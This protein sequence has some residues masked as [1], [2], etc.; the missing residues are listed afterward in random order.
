[1]AQLVLQAGQTYLSTANQI[2]GTQT[3]QQNGDGSLT[4]TKDQ[5][6]SNVGIVSITIDGVHPNQ[7]VQVNYG[8]T[9]EDIIT[10]TYD[11]TVVTSSFGNLSATADLLGTDGAN[12]LVA[13][14]G[15]PAGGLIIS[16]GG[17]TFGTVSDTFVPAFTL[18]CF[19]PGTLIRTTEGDIAVEQ[20]RIGDR[21]VSAFGG[22]APVTWIGHRHVRCARH[23]RP[24]DVHPIRVSA[25]A[26]G[27]GQPARDLL[28]SP[29][30]AIYYVDDDGVGALIPV[31]Y[32]INGGTIARETLDDVTYWHVE[33]PAHDVLFANGLPAESYLETGNRA[34]FANGG[35]VVRVKPDFAQRMWEAEGC[36]PLVAAGAV[37]ARAR[38]HLLARSRMLGQ[39]HAGNK[40]RKSA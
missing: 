11:V 33:L 13:G 38:A 8:G 24:E 17:Q 7:T 14:Q 27:P 19:G 28:L 21:V 22:D 40:K 20:L 10:T 12:V 23:D 3:S 4:V 15:F 5:N 29:D 32:L 25:G 1:M 9:T 26:F 36:A 30:H 18:A 31:R 2:A 34:A 16:S 6:A 39:S 35:A 37:L